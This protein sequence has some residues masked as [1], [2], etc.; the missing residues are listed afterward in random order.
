MRLIFFYL[1]SKNIKMLFDVECVLSFI[2]G[3]TQEDCTPEEK[4]LIRYK[5]LLSFY[6][7]D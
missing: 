4:D 5:R 1:I 2:N 7:T 6:V 3:T